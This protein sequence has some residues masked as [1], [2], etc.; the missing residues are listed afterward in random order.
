MKHW[1]TQNGDKIEYKK[2]EDSHLLN[3]IKWIDRRAEI[4]GVVTVNCGYA[5]DNDYVEYYSYEIFGDDVRDR[6]DYEGLLKE[7]KRRKLLI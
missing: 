7:V 6:Y 2:L 3:I 5:T 1:I 4:G